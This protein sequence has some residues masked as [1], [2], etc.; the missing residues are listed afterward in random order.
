M[1][2]LIKTELGLL[3][4]DNANWLFQQNIISREGAI[5]FVLVNGM[6]EKKVQLYSYFR[7][8]IDDI[9]NKVPATPRQIGL[10]V[11]DF[12]SLMRTGAVEKEYEIG[13][14]KFTYRAKY[15]KVENIYN[16]G[17]KVFVEHAPLGKGE[18]K[19]NF[20]DFDD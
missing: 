8:I 7:W 19:I 10:D 12:T 2:G 9:K 6:L 16:D 1:E 18:K 20:V 13:K 17:R 15:P 5:K 3:S 11:D 4:R 14:E